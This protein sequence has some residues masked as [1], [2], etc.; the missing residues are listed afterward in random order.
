M[1]STK[2]RFPSPAVSSEKLHTPVEQLLKKDNHISLST[3]EI[4]RSLSPAPLKLPPERHPGPVETMRRNPPSGSSIDFIFPLPPSKFTDIPRSPILPPYSSVIPSTTSSAEDLRTKGDSDFSERPTRTIRRT[5]SAADIQ[6]PIQWKPLPAR[7]PDCISKRQGEVDNGKQRSSRPTG[8]PAGC[9]QSSTQGKEQPNTKSQPTTLENRNMALTTIPLPSS[10]VETQDG[11][12]RLTSEQIIWLH[13]NYRGEA[14]FLKAWGLHLTRD[15]DREQGL[16][17]IKMLMAA[18]SPKVKEQS[19]H[20]K[21]QSQVG[22][23]QNRPPSGSESGD[24]GALEI[25]EE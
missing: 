16:E 9:A 12:K 4:K 2:S 24:K 6:N 7:P 5:Q 11:K 14:T 3:N 18:E 15:A 22:K 19:R 25:I 23:L 17:I 13:R 10:N 21:L 1:R 20:N 8:L